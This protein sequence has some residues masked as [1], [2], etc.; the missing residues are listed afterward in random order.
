[1]ITN[2]V[3][4]TEQTVTTLPVTIPLSYFTEQDD[5]TV[6]DVSGGGQIYTLF[7]GNH[8]TTSGAGIP[9]GGSVTLT[10][11]I[12][13][14][15]ST[16]VVFIGPV[17]KQT[18]DFVNNTRIPSASIESFLDRQALT[19]ASLSKRVDTA[20]TIPMAEP[21]AEGRGTTLPIAVLRADK[22]MAFDEEG[23]VAVSLRTSTL[24]S[25]I[26]LNSAQLVQG[27]TDY[28]SVADTPENIVDYGEI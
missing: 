27:L 13:T 3:V 25:L 5:I 9:G 7:H 22:I 17:P 11:K 1:M 18:T 12:S 4:R 26:N 8:Y 14:G 23:N 21:G 20:L 2:P 19:A 6:Y 15:M 10:S 24:Q 16:I 28:G